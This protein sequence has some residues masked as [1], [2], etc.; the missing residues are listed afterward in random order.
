M[1]DEDD[2]EKRNRGEWKRV[3][4]NRRREKEILSVGVVSSERKSRGPPMLPLLLLLLL[5]LSRASE[6][7]APSVVR[8]CWQKKTEQRRGRSNFLD[9]GC[10]AKVPQL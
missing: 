2:G 6:A 7:V 9:Y 10:D 1:D 3:T 4:E 5:L 8:S